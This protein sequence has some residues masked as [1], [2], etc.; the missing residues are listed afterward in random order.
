MKKRTLGFCFSLALAAGAIAAAVPA[1]AEVIDN[2]DFFTDYELL[3]NLEILEDEPAEN[4]GVAVST[5]PAVSTGTVTGHI[6]T[7]TVKVSS[8]T[9]RQYEKN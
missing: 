7:G 3:S 4:A 2:L 6:S 9:R 1:P 5:A 8:F